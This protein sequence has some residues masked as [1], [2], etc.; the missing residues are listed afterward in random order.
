[1]LCYLLHDRHTDRQ[2]GTFVV[3]TGAERHD[4][5]RSMQGGSEALIFGGRKKYDRLQ[6]IFWILFFLKMHCRHIRY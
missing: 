6:P 5:K 4:P 2:S 3:H 1:M